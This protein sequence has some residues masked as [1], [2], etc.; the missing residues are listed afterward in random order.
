MTDKKLDLIAQLLAK[1]ES[2]TP[3]EAE[4]LTEAA[5]RLMI[6]Y[7]I[8]QAMIDD[9]RARQGHA[10]ERIVE[11]SMRF[12]GTYAI[13][14]LELG[15]CVAHGLGALRC[16]QSSGFG[17]SKVLYLVGYESD[18]AQAMT[19]IRSLELQAAVALRAW[20][21]GVRDNYSWCSPSQKRRLRGSFIRGFGSG[22]YKRISTNRNQA[23]Q[24]AGTGTELVLVSRRER[25]DAHMEDM[26]GQLGKARDRK[27]AEG[28][29]YHAGHEAGLDAHTG[30]RSVDK[31]R[32]L[33]A[34]GDR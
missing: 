19:L 13:D 21:R 10:A 18:V 26:Y 31:G 8:E 30:E 25:V 15:F 7:G 20:W 1:A 5:E 22:V 24:E 14:L 27:P 17:G 34:G 28:A 6:K 32:A 3:E 12:E 33:T 4:A 11:E 9:R 23:V 16:L 2:T 29:S